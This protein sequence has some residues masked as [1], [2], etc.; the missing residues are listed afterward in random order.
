MNLDIE[1][2]A[3]L[4]EATDTIIEKN[5][6][7]LDLA[8]FDSGGE[9]KKQMNV[10]KSKYPD[11]KVSYKQLQSGRF[12]MISV[13][14][15]PTKAVSIKV[16][17]EEK[18]ILDCVIAKDENNKLAYLEIYDKHGFQ[19]RG[20]TVDAIFQWIKS[21]GLSDEATNKIIR[22]KLTQQINYVLTGK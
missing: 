21:T 16:K 5:Y 10:I 9:C 22:E 1:L 15:L 4:A 12:F 20:K 14:T 18:G 11:A 7:V 19:F 17:I 2:M 6:V 3:I 8:V 13:E